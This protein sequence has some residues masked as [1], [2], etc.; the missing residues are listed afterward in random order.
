MNEREKILREGLEFF[1]K[2][3]H[4][5]AMSTLAK[6]D[7]ARGGWIP[8]IKTKDGKMRGFRVGSF[9]DEVFVDIPAGT[10]LYIE[11]LK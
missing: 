4:S 9:V 10:Q 5:R 7:A 6:A 8:I 3:G 2:Q 11:A 1:V